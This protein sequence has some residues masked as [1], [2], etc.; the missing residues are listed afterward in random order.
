MSKISRFTTLLITARQRRSTACPGEP[1][2]HPSLAGAS[3][4]QLGD[5]PIPAFSIDRNCRVHLQERV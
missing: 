3:H 1:L 2:D 5:L 4:A